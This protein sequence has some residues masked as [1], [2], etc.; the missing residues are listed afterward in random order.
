MNKK[1]EKILIIGAG[2]GREH[3][4]GWKIVQSPRAGQ[5][6][7]AR[8][9]AGTEKIGTNLDIKETDIQKLIEFSKMEKIDLVLAV[10][11]D[12]PALGVVD[13]F[14]KAGFRTWG[15]SKA[16]AQLEWSKAFSKD[17]MRRHNLP[18]AKFEI[19]TDYSKAK[20]YI[21]TQP[22][23]IVIKASGLALGKGVV[24]AHTKGE[25]NETLEN[26]MVKKVFGDSGSEVVIEEFM[27]GPEISIHAFS[28]GKNYKMFPPSQDHKKIGDGDIGP[29]TGG[30]GAISPLPFVDSTLLKIIEETIV[31]PTLS[32]LAEEGK[33]FVGIL[34]PGL[35]LTPEGPKLLEYNARFGD[36]EAETYMRLLDTDILDIFDACIDGTLQNLEIKW[37]NLSACNVVLCSG[38]Y[39]GNYEKGKIISGIDEAEKEKDIVIF[40]AGTKK[41]GENIVTNGG[42]VLGVSATG[43]NLK[44]AL[45]KAYKAI[46][47]ISFEGMHYRK[48]IG[49]KALMLQK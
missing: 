46:E 11:D 40:Y 5:L 10:S 3:A 27:T 30:I 48:D 31:A 25:A 13:E 22:L 23:P 36:P 29:N 26:M 12:P 18:T 42:R 14:Q 21:A 32:A 6:F 38:G 41:E 15:P 43:E 37:K 17:F 8:G 4:L 9:N 34:Y 39:P 16:A 44:E 49:K 19:F 24:I 45:Q 47:K 2:G 20:E 35:M 7:F 28:D 1:Y 33:P